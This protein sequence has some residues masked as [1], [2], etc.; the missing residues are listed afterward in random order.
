[1]L[2]HYP[3]R[4]GYLDQNTFWIL[5]VLQLCHHSNLHKQCLDFS[6]LR[7]FLYLQKI[8]DDDT[9]NN[10]SEMFTSMLTEIGCGEAFAVKDWHWSE[11]LLWVFWKSKHFYPYVFIPF[12]IS[13]NTSHKSNYGCS[14]EEVY[15]AEPKFVSFKFMLLI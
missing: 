13:S 15:K 8:N 1:M 5:C 7:Y 3:F 9:M 6:V 10:I 11:W 12:K 2:R 4:S 14:S